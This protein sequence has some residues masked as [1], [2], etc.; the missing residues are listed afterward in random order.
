[1]RRSPAGPL[2]L[3]CA[4]ALV[5]A[6]GAPRAL[7]QDA[8]TRPAQPIGILTADMD[9][10]GV[11]EGVGDSVFVAGRVSAGTGVLRADLNEVYLQDGTGGIRLILGRE[12]PQVFTGDSLLV[13][14][15]LAFRDGMAEIVDP[16][17][18]GIQAEPRV[19]DH[20]R[21]DLQTSTLERHESELVEVEGTVVET[22]STSDGWMMVL[23]VREELVQVFAYHN[24]LGEPIPMGRLFEKGDYVRASGIAVQYDPV[25]PYTGGYLILPRAAA[26]VRR[27]GLPPSF[28]RWAALAV[29]LLLAVALLWMALLRREVRRRATLLSESETRYGH[30]FD[31]AGDVV[32]V[33]DADDDGL[34]I[35]ANKVAQLSFG[36]DADGE[37]G[38]TELGLADLA[39]DPDE[40][41]RHLL[42]ARRRGQALDVIEM[43]VEEGAVPFEVSTRRLALPTG[44]VFVSVA[45]DVASRRAYEH[46][47]LQAMQE[48]EKAREEAEAAARLKSAIL[49]NMSHEI[50]TPLTAIIGFADILAE[51]APVQLLDHVD[52]IQTGGTRLLETLNSVLDLSR[53]DA[54]QGT[55]AAEPFDAAAALRESV[56]LLGPLAKKK[57]IG[58]H[59][60]A[61]APTLPV[62]QSRSGLD[63]VVTNLVGNAIKFTERGEVRVS[64]HSAATYFALRVRDSGVGI[65][66]AFLPELFEP[67][68]QESQGHARSHE[69]TGLGLAITKRLVERMGGEIRV[70][71]RKGEGTLFEVALPRVGPGARASAP[72]P[73]PAPAVMSF[74]AGVEV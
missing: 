40:A 23:L 71:S 35:E 57:H 33:H 52:A 34:I 21:L 74:T 46:G 19:P 69:G 68:K 61:D 62:R 45:R 56:G 26:D 10:D 31:A 73:D 13:R 72:E 20:V 1:M 50:R 29:G 51:E 5:G 6:L 42:D 22:D 4:A 11:P 43:G 37:R 48:A 15:A 53:L 60:E 12:A 49:A 67:F 39:A 63:R 65:D 28:F 30:L 70:W 8:W 16:A 17:F 27:A 25:A 36:I 58:L 9:D 18:R 44:D 64:L 7:A 32:L 38:G 59:I 2:L 24:R 14:G 66:E 54:E 3:L 55:L 47:I 41:R